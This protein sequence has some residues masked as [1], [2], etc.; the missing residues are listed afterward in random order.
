MQTKVKV[1]K[2]NANKG[3]SVKD[4]LKHVNCDL[5]I[6]NS[7]HK[8]KRNTRKILIKIKSVI[9]PENVN[10]GF[11]ANVNNVDVYSEAKM[12]SKVEMKTTSNL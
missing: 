5:N 8:G 6:E 10:N 4:N 1:Q 11:F 3:K 9:M 12:L 7:N 2:Q